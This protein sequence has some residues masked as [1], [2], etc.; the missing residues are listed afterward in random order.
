MV[1]KIAARLT[2]S[3][4]PPLPGSHSTTTTMVPPP[5]SDFVDSS[6]RILWPTKQSISSLVQPSPDSC[7][8]APCKNFAALTSTSFFSTD[9]RKSLLQYVG[10]VAPMTDNLYDQANLV[11][12][13]CPD[14]P[15]HESHSK[16]LQLQESHIV[17]NPS[18]NCRKPEEIRLMRSKRSRIS[19]SYHQR[20]SPLFKAIKKNSL[21]IPLWL[22]QPSRGTEEFQLLKKKSAEISQQRIFRPKIPLCNLRKRKRAQYK[23]E[24]LV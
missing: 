3:Q 11:G 18:H 15:T 13:I 5:L 9:F 16:P 20:H 4:R 10:S 21:R 14:A 8:T 2:C 6:D 1:K 24:V 7:S 23:Y 12:L 19:I 22:P 17:F